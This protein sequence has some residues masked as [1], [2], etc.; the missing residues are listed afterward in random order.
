MPECCGAAPDA[1]AGPPPASRQAT[2]V[3]KTG[4]VAVAGRARSGRATSTTGDQRS[5]PKYLFG[6]RGAVAARRRRQRVRLVG[7]GLRLG[8][9]SGVAGRDGRGARSTRRAARDGRR[10]CSARRARRPGAGGAARARGERRLR[11]PRP[12]RTPATAFRSRC[13][14]T[15]PADVFVYAIDEATADGPAAPPTLI[16]NGIVHV[17]RCAH[18]EHVAGAALA[19]ECS[20]C[21]GRVCGDGR[22]PTAARRPGPTP[23]PRPP[24]R[25]TPADSSA[26]ANSRSFAAVTTGW[27]EAPATGTY[28]FDSSLQPSRLFV[29]GTKVLDWFETSPGTT[30]RIDHAARPGRSITFAGI[31]SRRSPRGRPGRG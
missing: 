24:T 21:A 5:C 15:R 11:R 9:R 19:A 6:P 10:A 3:C 16:R 25:C 13:P 26:P 12:R 17:P 22:T 20:A 28:V 4:G 8:V 2:A 7:D 27:I 1:R 14:R 31:A 29:N 18:S 23:A 30:Q